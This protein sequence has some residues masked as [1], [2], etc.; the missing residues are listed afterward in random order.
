MN[1]K[2]IGNQG[3]RL[4]RDYLI[5][6][7]YKILEMNFTTRLGEI[8]IIAEKDNIISFVE[9]KTRRSLKYGMPKEAVNYRKMQ[10]IIRVA[11]NYI[12]YKIRD[13]R[14]YRFDVIEVFLSDNKNINHIED[15][16]WL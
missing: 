10:K 1:N 6:R 7:G 4:A 15:A 16:F 13:D 14:Q 3:E 5:E 8:D 2:D 11:E 9:V 12:A